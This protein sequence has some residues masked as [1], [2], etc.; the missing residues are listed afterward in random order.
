MILLP[1]EQSPVGFLP[2]EMGLKPQLSPRKPA[3]MKEEL[4]SLLLAMRTIDLHHCSWLCKFS[5]GETSVWTTS[6]P[7]A[8]M[9]QM[10]AAV[11]FVG[12]Y[13]WWLVQV[14]V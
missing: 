11:D 8:E 12:T 14:G 7:I 2:T 3:T 9:G 5:T 1:W 4:K 13:M 6:A 10:L